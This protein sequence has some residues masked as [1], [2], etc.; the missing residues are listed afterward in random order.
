MSAT[1]G[2]Q[3]RL[4]QTVRSQVR[5]L[6]DNVQLR[7]RQLK[8]ATTWGAQAGL[9]PLYMLFQAS[10]WGGQVLRQAASNGKQT[11]LSLARGG[12]TVPTDQP[13]QNVLNAIEPVSLPMVGNSPSTAIELVIRPIMKPKSTLAVLRQKLR[14]L[15]PLQR[16]KAQLPHAISDLSVSA[17]VSI[18]PPGQSAVVAQSIAIQGIASSLVH[19]RLVLVTSDHQILD[20]L[21][22]DQQR[23]LHQRIIWEIAQAL[24][25][26]RQL[27][28]PRAI[29]SWRTWKAL[30]IKVRSQ[31]SFPVRVIYHLM[32]WVQHQPI[33]QLPTLPESQ[34][35]FLPSSALAAPRQWWTA[36]LPSWTAI[37]RTLGLRHPLGE[38][39]S[40]TQ[41]S[42]LALAPKSPP[43]LP[44]IPTLLLHKLRGYRTALVAVAGAI[45]L[46]PFTLG[47]AE[48]AKAAMT[49]ALPSPLPSPILVERLIDPSRSRRRWQ[50]EAKLSEQSGRLSQGKVRIAPQKTAAAQS[51]QGFEGAIADWAG[52]FSQAAT[53]G[54]PSTIEVNAVF[55]GYDRHPL[56]VFLLWLDRAIAWI[57]GQFIK[58]RA[59]L[60]PKLQSWLRQ[61]WHH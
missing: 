49:P 1:P 23:Q 13:I 9:Y 26:R 8:V 14:T 39:L 15:W 43:L 54:D 24:Y 42:P 25:L 58:T 11:L 57:E 31:H 17:S 59:R 6:K 21:T 30:P 60:W 7:W 53:A 52:R 61:Y 44:P 27:D 35:L 16:T 36:L 3:S 34:P 46:L 22:A 56:E 50:A 41:R 32:A 5:Q 2:Y 33:A 29:P 4:F 40:L 47:L 18:Q 55:M 48:P 19:R 28:R 20:V 12:E 37:T 38:K 51:G 10:R 45:A